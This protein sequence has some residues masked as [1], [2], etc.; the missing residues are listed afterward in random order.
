M[1]FKMYSNISVEQWSD[2]RDYD[3]FAEAESLYKLCKWIDSLR[4]KEYLA[5]RSIAL[6]GIQ[7]VVVLQR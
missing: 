2:D 6:A 1:S 7:A 5:T 3:E 4:R